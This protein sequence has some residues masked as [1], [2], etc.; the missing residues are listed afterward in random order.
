MIV[1]TRTNTSESMTGFNPNVQNQVQKPVA[2]GWM[3]FLIVIFFVLS[4]GMFGFWYIS[5]RNWFNA[6]QI[7]INTSASNIEVQLLQRRDTLL[8]L[9]DATKSHMKY[10]KETL[11]QIIGLRSN[12]NGKI[13]PKDFGKVT[14]AMSQIQSGINAVFERYPNLMAAESVSKLMNSAEL[15]E[16]E[17]AASRRL[18][19]QDVNEFNQALFGFPKEFIAARNNLYTMPLFVASEQQKQDVNLNINI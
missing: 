12:D 1:D 5:Q 4:L 15:N 7:Q 17:I 6:K 19:N 18:Y 11:N 2:K 3:W 8:K 9:V 10:E 14:D 13:D 16:R